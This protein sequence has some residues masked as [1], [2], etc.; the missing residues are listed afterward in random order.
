MTSLLS[1]SLGLCS[2]APLR[3]QLRGDAAAYLALISTPVGAV[4]PILTAPML[5]QTMKNVDFAVRFGHISITDGSTNAFDARLGIP[6]GQSVV[7]GVN[8]GYQGR[9]CRAGGCQGHFIGGANIEGRFASVVLGSNADAAQ[10]TVGLNGE[11]GFGRRSGTALTSITG[12][13][14]VA[15]VSGPLHLRVAPFLT[16]GIGWGRISGGGMSDMGMRFLLGGGVMFQ[17]LTT[18]V[19]ATVGFQKALIDNGDMMF[20]IGLVLSAR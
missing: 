7:V 1:L 20:G 15:L 2:A 13:L 3:A 18:G 12:G 8:G 19:G 17:S 11:I 10:L 16:P 4:P 9:S 5:N 14:P 6:A